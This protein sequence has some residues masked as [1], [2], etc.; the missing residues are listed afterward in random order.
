M[1][2]SN[3]FFL[4]LYSDLKK[5]LTH[6]SPDSLD[7]PKNVYYHGNRFTKSK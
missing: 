4:I 2:V 5:H 7:S 1:V 6:D 3:S